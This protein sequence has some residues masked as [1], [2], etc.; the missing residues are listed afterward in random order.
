MGQNVRKKCFI[1]IFS[2]FERK[3]AP[4][5]MYIIQ[6]GVRNSGQFFCGIT[7]AAVGGCARKEKGKLMGGGPNDGVNVVVGTGGPEDGLLPSHRSELC[8]E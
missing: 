2:I 5:P 8:A 3:L 7:A 4:N 1:S 6:G